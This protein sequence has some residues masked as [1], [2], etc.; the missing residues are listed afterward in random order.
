MRGSRIYGGVQFNKGE[1][2]TQYGGDELFVRMRDRL[3]TIVLME[4]GEEETE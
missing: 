4:K 3:S 1:T 2:W